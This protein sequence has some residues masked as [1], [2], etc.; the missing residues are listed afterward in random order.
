MEMIR[1]FRKIVT[2]ISPILSNKIMYRKMCGKKLN[3]KKPRTFNE[4]I[5][6]LKIFEYPSDKRIIRCADKYKMHSFLEE[7]KL[8]KYDVK[9]LGVWDS[10]NEINFND[11]PNKFVL[12]CNHGSRYNIICKDK[13]KFDK[14]SAIL[15]LNKWLSE[16]FGLVSGELHYS[17]IPRKIICEE[18]L[19]EN[20]KDFQ[21]WCSNGKILF[22]VYINN[23]H[24]EN[25]KITLD[26]DWNELP[27]VTSLPKISE[28]IKKPKYLKEMLEISKSISKEFT[29]LRMD[30]YILND[31]NIKIS[32]LTFSPASGFV[33]WNPSNADIKYG[34]MLSI[35]KEMNQSE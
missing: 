20:I 8:K 30:F 18:Y 26:E 24:G 14:K 1:T 3:L 25:S 22:T 12:K 13:S 29:F 4:K 19:G 16:D 11:L 33:Q 6:W 35:E 34:E 27:F 9:L 21:V 15:K 7:K 31:E 2:S 32:E 10:A 23:P 28:N 5:N 17:M